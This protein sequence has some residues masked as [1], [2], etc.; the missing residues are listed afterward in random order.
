[1]CGKTV[2]N[3]RYN[4]LS[5]RLSDEELEAIDSLAKDSGVNRSEYIRA[6]IQTVL[7][8]RANVN[9]SNLW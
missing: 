1:M 6:M 3:P 9:V 5:I 2:E 4:V 8:W 7:E